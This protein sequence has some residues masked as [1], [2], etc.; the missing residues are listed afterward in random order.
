MATIIKLPTSTTQGTAAPASFTTAAL[1]FTVPSNAKVEAHASFR[2]TGT[3]GFWYVIFNKAVAGAP[4]TSNYSKKLGPNDGWTLTDPP[5]GDVWF[6]AD[7]SANGNLDWYGD[8][9]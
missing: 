1:G 2:N 3:A 8:W 7:G 9:A 5:T 6:L 4:T